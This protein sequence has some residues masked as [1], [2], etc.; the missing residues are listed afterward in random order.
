MRSVSAQFLRC[1]LA[2]LSASW[3]PAFGDTVATFAD[4]AT[5]GSTPL[6]TVDRAASLLR[7]G[8]Q[9]PGLDLR[10]P[11][12]GPNAV[13]ENA[14]FQMTDVPI[15]A[16]GLTLG[17]GQ[18]DFFDSVG[19]LLLTV[20]FERACLFEPFGFG[21]GPS[22]DDGV[23]I[24]LANNGRHLSGASFAFAFANRSA[25]GPRTTYTAAFTSS[26]I[27][28]APTFVLLFAGLIGMLGGRRSVFAGSPC[29]AHARR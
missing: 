16:D 4:P 9:E 20:T 6:V 22:P 17:S 28:E 13:F 27:P 10:V 12:L 14:T 2:A 19:G 26:G 18:I 29:A 1:T 11:M 3:L 8:W 25:Q 24:V 21:A 15:L 7:A 5:D 23:H